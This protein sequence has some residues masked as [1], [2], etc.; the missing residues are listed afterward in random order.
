MKKSGTNNETLC[1]DY[2]ERNLLLHIFHVT[3][4]WKLWK[5]LITGW[6]NFI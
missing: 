1:T 2:V 5:N 4:G 3:I 6:K